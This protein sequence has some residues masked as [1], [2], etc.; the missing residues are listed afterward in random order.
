MI[1]DAVLG[2]VKNGLGFLF[3][4]QKAKHELRLKRMEAGISAMQSSWT[5]EFLVLVWSSPLIVGWFSP[6]LAK[7]WFEVF[8]NAPNWYQVGWISI[9]GAVFAVPK[10]MDYAFRR[11]LKEAKKDA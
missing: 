10:L 3:E 8:K 7:A 5:D 4:T 2:L 1:L 11:H 9:T 6:E